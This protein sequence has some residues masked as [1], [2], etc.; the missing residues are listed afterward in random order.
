MS[1]IL[2]QMQ[3]LQGKQL[4]AR[5]TGDTMEC[6]QTQEK[7]WDVT[8][9]SSSS[10]VQR[11]STDLQ[12]LMAEKGCNPLNNMLATACQVRFLLFLNVYIFALLSNFTNQLIAQSL[13]VIA[14]NF[15]YES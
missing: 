15:M 6:K 1:Y 3:Y 7:H 9:N 5:R 14:F 2:P 10:T 8:I 4:A 12:Q 13:Y 11:Y